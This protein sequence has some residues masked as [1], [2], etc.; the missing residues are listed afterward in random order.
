MKIEFKNESDYE[1]AVSILKAAGVL[2]E[3]PNSFH[4]NKEECYRM[5][6]S[7]EVAFSWVDSPHGEDYW[8]DIYNNVIHYASKYG[9]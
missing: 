1:K 7:L 9:E 2:S 3:E 8:L 5:I 4:V 6:D